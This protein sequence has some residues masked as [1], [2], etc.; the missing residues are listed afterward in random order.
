MRHAAIVLAWLACLPLL[1]WAGEDPPP[2]QARAEAL[3]LNAAA[4]ARYQAG[5]HE[6]ALLL[7]REALALDPEQ[8]TIRKNAGICL[9]TLGDAHLAARR[10][11]AA[12]RDY[13]EAGELVP[14][15]PVAP[16]REAAALLEAGRSR[17]AATLLERV[18][19]DHPELAR[20]HRLLGE[21]RYRLGEN[22]AAIAAW[23]Q[24]LAL[25][26]Q[27]EALRQALARARREE[28]VEGRL[29]VDLA[30]PHFTIKVDGEADAELGRQVARELEAA[31][32]RVGALLGRYPPA[33]VAVVIY[34][35][36]SF[37]ALTGAHGWVAALYD[38]KIRVPA[39]GLQD[40]PP[41]E[42]RRL[43]T[44]EYAHALVRSVA[45]SGVPAWLHEGFAQVAEGRTAA[46][47]RRRLTQRTA[48]GASELTGS[49]VRQSDV[50][51]A[52]RRYDAACALLHHLLG[53]G[54]LPA[55]AE[56]LD[57]LGRGEAI[58][59]ALRQLY[60]G[61]LEALLADWRATLPPR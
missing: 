40:A 51:Q 8:E 14:A 12:I 53:Q 9:I 21:A 58:D 35:G 60:G 6:P 13:H 26:P 61:D 7:F 3:R 49:F 1:A 44:H 31:Y 59:A 17:D 46:D 32:E 52:A 18:V 37:R 43:L 38:G 34:P 54:G 27:D 15:D 23:E 56:L 29:A 4:V 28:A 36:R 20:A 48:P 5:E 30:A 50:R 10:L 39:A 57:R 2:Q 24:A 16:Q 25:A 22:A 47:A 45:G 19:R 41:A 11:E 55:L 42:V 33:E